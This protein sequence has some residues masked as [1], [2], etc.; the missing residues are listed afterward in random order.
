MALPAAVVG[1]GCDLDP[2]RALDRAV[3]EIVQVR[4]GLV[5]HLR[6]AQPPAPIERYEDVRS[7]DDHAA[8]AANPSNGPEF[9]FLVAGRKRVR[10]AEMRSRGGDSVEDKLTFCRERLE[11]AGSRLAFV[12]LTMPDLEPFPVRIVRTIATGLQP[13][14]FGFGEERLGGTRLF[15]VPRLL[16]YVDRDLTE[17]DLNPCPH[18]LA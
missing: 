13:I 14:H 6:Q 5:P 4:T 3:M 18:P 16:G 8:F 17:A 7:L 12:E 15:S 11:A 1:L 2:G 10:L 9:G